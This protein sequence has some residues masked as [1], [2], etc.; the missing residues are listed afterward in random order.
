MKEIID[1][2]NLNRPLREETIIQKALK[3]GYISFDR[4]KLINELRKRD[5]VL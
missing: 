3:F 1:K 2:L 5:L 4:K